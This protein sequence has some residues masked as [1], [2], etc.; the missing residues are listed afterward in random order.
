[1]QRDEVL[2][3]AF[4]DMERL[5]GDIGERNLFHPGCGVALAKDANAKVTGITVTAPFHI[6]VVEPDMITDTPEWFRT[7][8]DTVAAE[9]LAHVKDAG[10]C[11]SSKFLRQ[12]AGQM[13][14]RLWFVWLMTLRGS[15]LV[16]KRRR[17]MVWRLILS[18]CSRIIWPRPQYT[19]AGVRL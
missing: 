3:I 2:V 13:K 6:F 19:S 1:M 5:A 4:G 7:R 17:A 11:P 15:P 8:M 10:H 9:R 16:H 14:G 12:R 18:L